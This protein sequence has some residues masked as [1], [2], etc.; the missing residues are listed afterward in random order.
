M[1]ASSAGRVRNSIVDS[2]QEACLT[3]SHS[4][5]WIVLRK[6]IGCIEA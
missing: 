6:I 4:T 2:K 1:A 5:A 3:E